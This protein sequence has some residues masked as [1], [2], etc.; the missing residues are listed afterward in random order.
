MIFS[1]FDL[2]FN[3]TQEGFAVFELLIGDTKL[4]VI[5]NR[6]SGAILRKFVPAFAINL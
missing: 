1:F 5:S 3:G 4:G 2:F 6:E